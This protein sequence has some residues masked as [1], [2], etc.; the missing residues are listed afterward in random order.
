VLLTDG[1]NNAGDVQPLDAARIAKLLGVRLYTI[2]AVS[3]RSKGEVDERTMR[4][5]SALTGGQYYRANDEQTLREVYREIQTLEKA[6][7]GTRA[8]ISTEDAALPFTAAGAALLVVEL[9]FAT[10]LFRRAP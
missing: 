7:V 6:R 5:M 9:L 1:E 3:D 8:F 10:T 4:E 2:G